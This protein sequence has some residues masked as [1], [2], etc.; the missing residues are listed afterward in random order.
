LLSQSVTRKAMD[1][2]R[3][4]GSPAASGR[5]VLPS[6]A[7]LMQDP[8]FLIF[9]PVYRGGSIPATQAERQRTL[10][11]FVF[12]PLRPERLFQEIFDSES[13]LGIR[14][15][16]FDGAQPAQPA[17]ESLLFGTEP[18]ARNP[19]PSRFTAAHQ[20]EVAGETWTIHYGSLPG[21]EV[22][23]TT[24][25]L[26]YTLIP[27]ILISILLSLVTWS[28]VRGL[29]VAQESNA[30]LRETDEALRN[31]A[32]EKDTVL[33]MLAH[34][35]RNP[36]APIMASAHILESEGVAHPKV[37]RHQE[38]ISRQAG[39]MARLLD[40]LLDVSRIT[41]ND[42]TLRMQPL[43]LRTVVR[44]AVESSR[45]AAEERR[46]HLTV[47]LPPEPICVHGDPVRL[48][49][50][51][52]NLLSNAAKYTKP[53]GRIRL[54]LEVDL[55]DGDDARCHGAIAGRAGTAVLSVQDTGVGINPE[56]LPRIFDLFTQGS[57][58]LDRAEGGLGV[59]LTVASDLVRM[60]GGKLEARSEG[61][62][63]GSEFVLRLPLTNE[64]IPTETADRS[65]APRA[66]QPQA[67]CAD[68]V[69]RVLVIDDNQAA[70][71]TLAEMV[72]LW[73]YEVR[74][75]H[76]G[77][78]GLMLARE[79]S[80]MVAVLDIGLPG[81]DGYEVARR[82]RADDAT[83]GIHLIAVTGYGQEDDRRRSR[84]AGIDVHLT[85]P[86]DP[87]SLEVALAVTSGPNSSAPASR[88]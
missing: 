65:T 54:A 81:M 25:A 70:A 82:L 86:V 41:R 84:E 80:P 63:K 46:H 53:G 68:Q 29:R 21:M 1:R 75:A 34:E 12:S 18:L 52:W 30:V 19:L 67:A 61:A 38:I 88:K 5:A 71:E 64:V 35:L 85:K 87:S 39:I 56:L 50:V 16:I 8:E 2:A 57:R 47:S 73:G 51:V 59:G 15:H 36:L 40:D 43:D 14:F 11:G 44:N 74:I 83:S 31:A 48:E 60:H 28:Q 22:A 20:I 62:G 27:G 13:K 37:I 33:A 6:D 42:I 10:I 4:S 9:V 69:T 76:D 58:S 26:A 49:Q 23:R 32:R 45:P 55:K 17:R 79:Y 7:V 72:E 24:R 77:P 3:S 78:A 66:G